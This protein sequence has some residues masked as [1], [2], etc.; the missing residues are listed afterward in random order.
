MIDRF[1]QRVA[2]I[3]EL[4][5]EA[6][7][8]PK[9]WDDALDVMH[10]LLPGTQLVLHTRDDSAPGTTPVLLRGWDMAHIERYTRYYAALNPW[11][12][13]I[14]KA[15]LMVPLWTEN[16]LPSS[17]FVDSEFYADWLRGAGNAQSATGVKLFQESGR[18][19]SI[20]IHYDI[21]HMHAYHK[22]ATKLLST[23][24]P[25]LRRS[26]AATRLVQPREMQIDLLGALTDAAFLVDSRCVVRDHNGTAQQLLES[27]AMVALSSKGQLSLKPRARNDWL[28]RQVSA[29]CGVGQLDRNLA[30]QPSSRPFNI[31]VLPV[32]ESGSALS[33]IGSLFPPAL[34]ALII[35]QRREMRNDSSIR[36]SADKLFRLTPAEQKLI[37]ALLDGRSLS[38]AA[39]QFGTS[40]ETI[41]TQLRS[42]F[43]KT[44]THRQAE[45]VRLLMQ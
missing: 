40:R 12:P 14:A 15:P 30:V 20:D 7:F 23:I 5:D 19:A 18:N 17:S 10:L 11:V 43:L 8:N 34:L 26:I 21:R 1:S 45:L 16:T 31:V 29:A 41:R 6:A 13:I 44:G 3:G 36:N 35:F 27:A 4:I 42:I 28:Q 25:K 32:R 22:S 2:E 39:Q 33:G 37:S 38:E 24:A 9:R